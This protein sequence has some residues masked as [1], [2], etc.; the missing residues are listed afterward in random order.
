MRLFK[1]GEQIKAE[2]EVTL[3]H[4]NVEGEPR[5]PS[6]ADCRHAVLTI[7]NTGGIGYVVYD[8]LLCRIVDGVYYGSPDA[9]LE[10]AQHFNESESSPWDMAPNGRALGLTYPKVR[11]EKNIPLQIEVQDGEA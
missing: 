6:I 9:A 2:I 7:K 11:K 8:R 5:P 4:E 3:T 1:I 10:V